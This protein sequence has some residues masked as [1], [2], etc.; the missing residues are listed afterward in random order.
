MIYLIY[1]L[2][3]VLHTYIIII[4]I[5]TVYYITINYY[6]FSVANEALPCCG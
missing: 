4:C 5:H 3:I 2:L 1:N 6:Q